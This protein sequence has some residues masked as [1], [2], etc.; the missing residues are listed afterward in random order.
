M[1]QA[2]FRDHGMSGSR[3]CVVQELVQEQMAGSRT[4][5]L[6]LV[7]ELIQELPLQK[8]FKNLSLLLELFKNS[9]KSS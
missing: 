1:V 4:S 8:K 7:L 2:K 9:K 6:E 5:V 3:P